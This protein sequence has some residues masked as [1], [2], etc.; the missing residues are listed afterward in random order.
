MNRGLL[1]L[2]YLKH[3]DRHPGKAG[4]GGQTSRQRGL[5]GGA[6]HGAR[7]GNPFARTALS[8]TNTPRALPPLIKLLVLSL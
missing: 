6:E 2:P 7:R 4:G 1:I 8:P 3:R 5:G